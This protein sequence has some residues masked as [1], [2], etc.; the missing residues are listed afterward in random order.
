MLE[1]FGD[2]L[3]NIF[4]SLQKPPLDKK[5]NFFR[6]LAVCQKAGLWIR[7]SLESLQQ[8]EDHK[9]L[10]LILSGLIDSLTQGLNLADAMAKYPYFFNTDEIELLRSTEVT[11]NMSAVLEQI[12]SSLEESQQ[13]NAKVKK[14][15]TMPAIVLCFTFVAV[16]VLLIFVLPTIIQMY[17]SVDE[18]P[19][20]TQFMLNAS[21][22]LKAYGIFW[23]IG[24]VFAVGLY[25]M[26]YDNALAFKIA[27]DSL[28][29]QIPVASD[30]VR[31]Y[32]ISKFTSLLA[33]F[34]AAWVSPVVSFKMLSDIFE[35][36][37]YK[38]KMIEVRNSINAGFSIYESLEWS[39]L[40]DPILAQIIHVWEETWALT[41]ALAR[42]APFYSNS[43]KNSI[44]AFMGVLEPLLMAFIACIVGVLLGAIYLP[45]ADMVNQIG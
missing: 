17:T 30:I 18:L 33:Q 34:Y 41:D 22:Y 29:L 42:I 39:D 25:N 7:A 26:L 2:K 31:M 32:Y 40:F 9:G 10:L 14:A 19:G 37:Q 4:L 27:I 3:N 36:F 15:L 1:N 24:I 23:G 38:K 5:V 45:M 20:I 11:G 16:V 13:I 12:A 44:D 43:L 6:L 8:G 21:D 28:I 35:N